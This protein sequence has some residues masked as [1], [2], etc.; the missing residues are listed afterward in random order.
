MNWIFI[1]VVLFLLF[2]LI[3]G[4]RRGGVRV[5]FGMIG[6]IIV[7]AFA[8]FAA[9]HVNTFLTEHTSIYD[10]VAEKCEEKIKEKSEEKIEEQ[11]ESVTGLLE[12]TGITL[13]Q[14]EQTTLQTSGTDAASSVLEESGVYSTAAQSLANVIVMVISF[15]ICLIIGAIIIGIIQHFLQR[16]MELPGLRTINKVMGAI[17]GVVKGLIV[18]WIVFYLVSLTEI[19]NENGTIVTMIQDNA[20]LNLLYENNILVT[21]MQNVF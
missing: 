20:F 2:H 17:L 19:V 3:R 1:I 11:T 5:L 4:V 8:I 7:L 16:L 12:N 9:P 18:V 21:I 6:L 10:A 14:D 15:I 13:S